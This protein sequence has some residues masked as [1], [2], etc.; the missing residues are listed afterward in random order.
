ME[1]VTLVDDNG[2]LGRM[3]QVAAATQREFDGATLVGGLAVLARCQHGR[4]TQDVDSVI[5]TERSL[6]LE[7]AR[8]GTPTGSH[9]ADVDGVMV[10]LIPVQDVVVGD[11]LRSDVEDVTDRLFVA[12]HRYAVDT[13][14]EVRVGTTR[15]EVEPVV[16]QVAAPAALLATKAH[17]LRDRASKGA[18]KMGSDLVD[19]LALCGRRGDEVQAGLQAAPAVL[20]SD[21]ITCLRWVLE[22]ETRFLQVVRAARASLP[23]LQPEAAADRIMSVL[24]T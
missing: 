20:R 23:G 14:T 13:A 11:A 17:A 2:Q 19:L 1:S 8:I 21:V 5:E 18:T 7:L 16:L 3:L 9:R 6:H 22:D 24:P 15:T 4:A 12:S 10:D